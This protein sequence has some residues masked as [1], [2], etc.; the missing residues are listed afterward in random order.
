MLN[1][2]LSHVL[3][4]SEGKPTGH[5]SVPMGGYKGLLCPAPQRWLHARARETTSKLSALGSH[6]KKDTVFKANR[7]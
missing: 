2:C 6:G 1:L 7:T 5:I 3:I 4:G